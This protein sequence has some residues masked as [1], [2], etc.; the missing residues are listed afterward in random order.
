MRP[1]VVTGP[2]R[3]AISTTS[4]GDGSSRRFSSLILV[5]ENTSNGP[6]KSRTSMSSKRTMPTRCLFIAISC[7]DARLSCRCA[8]AF[9][10]SMV[11]RRRRTKR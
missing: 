9:T 6:Q 1:V 11:P 5:T 4:K 2:G 3:S 7:M 8:R 10:M